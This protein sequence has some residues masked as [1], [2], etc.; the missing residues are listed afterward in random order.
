LF[1]IYLKGKYSIFIKIINRLLYNLTTGKVYTFFPLKIHY[2]FLYKETVKN[3]LNIVKTAH[4][5]LTET[6]KYV[7]V[8]FKLLSVQNLGQILIPEVNIISQCSGEEFVGGNVRICMRTIHFLCTI[9]SLSNAE[10]SVDLYI[11][12]S[13]PRGHILK[14]NNLSRGQIKSTLLC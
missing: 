3:N 7:H 12:I 5:S 4:N 14:L 8:V 2:L 1:L 6:P 10:L 11:Y 13:I 9:L